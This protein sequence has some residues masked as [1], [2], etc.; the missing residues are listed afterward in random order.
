MFGVKNTESNPL[1]D[2]QFINEYEQAD[3]A[4]QALLKTA[5][6]I[7]AKYIQMKNKKQD[8]NITFKNKEANKKTFEKGELVLHRQ[9]QVSTG[10]ASKWKPLMTGP[11]VIE[12]VQPSQKTA[13]CQNIRNGTKIKAHFTN[14][15]RYELDEKTFRLAHQASGLV[16]PK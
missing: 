1:I 6:H 12:E 11:Y 15:T 5:E 3:P 16:K 10:I 4:I 14:L 13:I 9:L 8:I 7:R 2:I